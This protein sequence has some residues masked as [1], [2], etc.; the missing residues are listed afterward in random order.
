VRGSTT[1]PPTPAI[2]GMALPWMCSIFCACYCF[3]FGFA[4][5]GLAS[6]SLVGAYAVAL[7]LRLTL[8][9]PAWAGLIAVMDVSWEGGLEGVLRG[10]LASVGFPALTL[11][12]PSDRDAVMWALGR[13]EL[14]GLPAAAA[15]AAAA[16]S[17]PFSSSSNGDGGKESMEEALFTNLPAILARRSLGVEG[18]DPYI[19]ALPV[20]YFTLRLRHTL[21]VF[22]EGESGMEEEEEEEEMEEEKKEMVG[23]APTSLDLLKKPQLLG[24]SGGM[25]GGGGFE[26][27]STFNSDVKG[28]PYGGGR[29][30]GGSSSVPTNASRMHTGE[31][32]PRGDPNGGVEDGRLSLPKLSIPTLNNKSLSD[33]TSTSGSLAPPP[34]PPFPPPPP[35]PRPPPPPP[36]M[37]APRIA[38]L[39]PGS[40]NT[41]S[42]TSGRIHSSM[43]MAPRNHPR[44]GG[45]SS[46][47]GA[48][49]SFPS[50]PPST[51]SSTAGSLPPPSIGMLGPPRA[52]PR[53]LM[54][55]QSTGRAILGEGQ[56]RASLGLN[57]NAPP[58]PF[59]PRSAPRTWGTWGPQVHSNT[60]AI[61]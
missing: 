12:S 50:S 22:Q 41:I 26:S 42:S 25:N 57:L 40:A 43:A 37:L 17:G 30:D 23:S 45:V 49:G 47:T 46:P 21:K 51:A 61:L 52:R 36:F 19:R 53:G 24:D 16:A 4:N 8:L 39:P 7:V 56:A 1:P 54:P 9:Q 5:G 35:P 31:T 27:V 10:A 11:V 59:P 6:N 44:W 29:S 55:L 20:L 58:R 2:L 34:P 13:L 60:T 28:D 38:S 33:T 48:Q 3:A 15:A 18:R 32:E 14:W